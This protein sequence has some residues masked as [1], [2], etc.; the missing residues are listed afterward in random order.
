MSNAETI[1]HKTVI[2]AGV[3]IIYIRLNATT[4]LHN[5]PQQKLLEYWIYYQFISRSAGCLW[6]EK[7]AILESFLDLNPGHVAVPSLRK[8][9]NQ[10]NRPNRKNS[11][12]LFN[13]I[14]SILKTWE[15]S[16]KR[17][18]SAIFLLVDAQQQQGIYAFYGPSI[19]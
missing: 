17:C 3:I 10:I 11:H 19:E 5:F 1:D 9:I 14:R 4:F 12:C 13:G 16:N 18:D 7:K 2:T 6:I 8:I 15:I